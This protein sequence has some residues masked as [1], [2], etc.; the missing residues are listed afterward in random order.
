MFCGYRLRC[1][2]RQAMLLA[3]LSSTVCITALA[4]EGYQS[5]F[6]GKDLTGWDGNP[7]LWS[8]QDEA[9][10]GVSD[11]S[12]KQNQFI[13][14]TGGNVSDFEL[15]LEFRMEG[16]S[17]SGVQY[18]SQR[19]P[20]TGP[21]VVGGYQADIHPA[22]KYTAML[23]E[24]RGR[25]IL[26][27][28]GQKV[29][30]NKEGKKEVSALPGT[31]ESVD[32]TQWHELVIKCEGTHLIHQ[33]DGV[34]VVD[35][36][37]AQEPGRDLE[38]VIAF[39]LH[40]GPPM[41]AQFRNIRLKS[42]KPASAA[43]SST[44]PDL[45][46]GSADVLAAVPG[47]KVELLYSVS[48]QQPGSLSTLCADSKGRLILGD[49]QG[50]LFRL[51]PNKLEGTRNIS[52]E[53]IDIQTGPVES[54]LWAF[55]SLY[56]ISRGPGTLPSGEQSGGVYRLRDSNGDDRLD[57]LERLRALSWHGN[58]GPHALVL[59]PDGT[60]IDVLCGSSTSLTELS[61][62]RV[63][64]IWDEDVLLPR[65]AGNGALANVA[66]PGGYAARMDRDGKHWELVAV[67]LSNPCDAAYHANGALLSCDAD[68]ETDA[69]RP[70]FRLPRICEILSGADYGWRSGS[71]RHLEFF[72]DTS[73][74]ILELGPGEPRAVC[75]GYGAKFPQRYQ[76]AFFVCQSHSGKIEAVHL[77]PEGA[78]F[79]AERE[80]FFTCPQ[81]Q[82][83][84]ILIH[85]HDG[86]M[87]LTLAG[88]STQAGLYR[89]TYAGMESVPA[90]SVNSEE[91]QTE[92]DLLRKLQALHA[93]DQPQ[94][95]AAAWPFLSHPDSVLRSAARTAIEFR[96]AEEWA[97]TAMN[98]ENQQAKLEALLA[99][100]RSQKRQLKEERVPIDSPA[101]DWEHGMGNSLG[102]KGVMQIGILTSLN[103]LDWTTFNFEQRMLGLRIVQLALLRCGQPDTFV[104]DALLN[105]LEDSLPAKRPETNTLLLE[106]LVYLQSP[107]AASQGM[108]LLEQTQIIEEQIWYAKSLAFLR[109]GW[110]PELRQQFLTWCRDTAGK[111][112][113]GDTGTCIKEIQEQALRLLN[114]NEKAALLQFLT[115]PPATH[116][117]HK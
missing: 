92:R 78:G 46:E 37:D 72:P 22:P 86:A 115:Q 111:P 73:K 40:V 49:R 16:K 98:E 13:S 28:R 83:T 96:P 91:G 10:T 84:D 59:S 50:N 24:E 42:L 54:L 5:L 17:N 25:G 61:A 67:G 116:P 105:A 60:G 90:A 29:T 18:R 102:T 79:A 14:W 56:F 44:V 57:E 4:E 104:R 45:S 81:L 71:A 51:V 12:L 89:I 95:I 68:S 77:R 106:T 38:G 32:L 94:A 2:M 34:T 70:W 23:Y 52:I 62:S 93:P 26:A 114:T 65:V 53:K 7:E 58:H 75:F 11:G 74:S 82:P 27:E 97:S 35:I 87:Y 47:F 43:Q 101:P 113:P 33:L 76:Q 55:D 85:P 9:I 100:C 109:V 20:D 36:N 64:A 63:P 88:D 41:K 19:M 108:K 110:T 6:N 1:L 80:E 117:S 30:I 3:L 99:L 15:K 66:A 103:S 48:K 69:G 107:Q 31:F 112:L 39:Q 8:V 21:W